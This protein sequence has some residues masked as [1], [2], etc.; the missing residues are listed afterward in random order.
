MQTARA[1]ARARG[2]REPSYCAVIA[3]RALDS[4]ANNNRK[5]I[6]TAINPVAA[7]ATKQANRPPF[8]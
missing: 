2:W 4:F 7:D 6:E 8:E 1:R 5:S 3:V